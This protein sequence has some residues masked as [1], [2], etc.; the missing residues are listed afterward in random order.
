MGTDAEIRAVVE[1]F[2][3]TA[4]Q[5]ALLDRGEE[6]LRLVAGQWE[7]SEW[8]GRLVLQ[9][10]A[11]ERNLSRRILAVTERGRDRLSLATERFP[12][13]PAELQIADLAAPEAGHLEKRM[14][15]LA[16]RDQF[17]LLLAREYPH[18]TVEETSADPNL[19]A[20]LSPAYV[21]AFLRRKGEGIA[22]MAAPPEALD[23]AGV[24]PFGLIW[25]DHLRRRE[26][27]LRIDRLL[28][29]VPDRRE[30][31]V[32]HRIAVLN[33]DRLQCAAFIYDDKLRI[34]QI[35]PADAGNVDSTLP[36]CR[37]AAVVAC[38][39]APDLGIDGVERVP[40]SAGSVSYEVRGLEFAR[41]MPALPA[42][43]LL[44][45]IGR[46]KRAS[47]SE[48]AALARELA[49]VRHG[50]AED[51]QHPLYTRNPEHWLEALVRANPCAIDASLLQYPIYGQAP[52]FAGRDRGV[53]DLLA[54]DH[55]G[56]LVVIELKTSE[57]IQLPFQAVDYWLRVSKHLAAGDFERLGYFAGATIR[58]SSPR[59]LL[60]APALSFHSTTETL[61]GYLD[62]RIRIMRAGISAGWR[63]ELRVVLRLEG[64]QRP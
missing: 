52:L 55:T 6:P 59:L 16:F 46:K 14:S 58:R 22:A 23:C 60:V 4:E 37:G 5:P 50:N 63:K 64:A 34:E 19:E 43:K 36:P 39:M 27:R 48:A 13:I 3:S 31:D 17:A 54:A 7:L 21:R 45:G 32:A 18:W 49:R 10:W 51:R 26:K 25:L 41:W 57:D 44:C 24:A 61:L 47:M 30:R 8:G 9:A 38:G 12:K 29:F 2:I 28:L 11:G 40:Q 35:D 33:P 62:P 20:S 15:R 42:G 53:V 56:E 1:E